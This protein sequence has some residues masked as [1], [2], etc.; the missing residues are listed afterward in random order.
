[1]R[2]AK[3]DTLGDRVV[4]VFYVRSPWGAKLT[5]A[6]ADELTLAIRHRTSRLL[7]G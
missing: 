2:V 6:Q 3:I 4:D 5:D 7:G 1:V